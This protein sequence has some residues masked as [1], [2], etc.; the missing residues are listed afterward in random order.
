MAKIQK[1]VEQTDYLWYTADLTDE[2]AEEYRN[3]LNALDKDED[4]DEPE[5]LYELEY[6]R[7]RDKPGSEDATF[8]LIED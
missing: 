7:R 1:F 3:Y 4:V 2:Q 8:E 5:W 6:E